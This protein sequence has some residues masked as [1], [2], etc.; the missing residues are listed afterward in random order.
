MYLSVVVPCFNEQSCLNVLFE[1]VTA[2]CR[3]A[4]GDNY[5]ILLINDGSTDRTWSMMADL[6]TNDSHVVAVNLSRNHGHQLALSAGLSMARG[7]KILVIDAD[8]QDPPEA[9]APMLALMDSEKADIV[10]GQRRSRSGESWFKKV[11]AAGFYR[12]LKR[13][14]DVDIP[15]DT[16]DFRLLTRRALNV[17]LSMPEQHRFIRGM[18]AWIGFRQVPYLYDRDARFA[19]ETKYPFKRMMRLTIDALT[20]F[21]MAPLRLASHLGVL[22]GFVGILLLAYTGFGWASGKAIA[23]WTSLMCVVIILGSV[24]M[25]ILG[26]IGE[27]LGR[28]YMQSK[29]RPMFI[30]SDVLGQARHVVQNSDVSSES[31]N[32]IHAL[33]DRLQRIA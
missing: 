2:S 11:T 24:Q 13:L 7:E 8:L 31:V 29:G 16:G 23:G 33:Q 17:F 9:L 10:Y 32:P 15:M 30:I 18:M 28:L 3:A 14:S 25:L 19:G 1:R 5:E 12:V 6:T 26:M 27:Y 4:V 20:G 22:L 21:S